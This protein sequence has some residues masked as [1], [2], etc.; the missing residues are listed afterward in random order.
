MP[1]EFLV[2]LLL[3]LLNGFFSL[4]EMALVSSRKARLK[5]EADKG[6]SAYQLAFKT[7]ESP[8]RYLSTIQVAITLI[9]I[10]TGTV[11]G[12]TIS[13]RLAAWLATFPALEK[14]AASISIAVVVLAITFLSVIIGELVPKSIALH[15]PE[16]IAAFTI[17]PMHF[18]SVLFFPV[19]RLLS[20]ATDGLVRLMGFHRAAE[21]AITPEEVKIL[22]EQG[23]ESGVFET[24][25]REMVEG[26]LNL[27]DRRVTMF[28]T[29][30]TDVVALDTADSREAHVRAIIEHAEFGYLPVVEGDLDHAI[31]MLE[32]KRALTR[33]A[34]GRF[35]G[36]RECMQSAVMIPESFSGL[37]ALGILKNA[38]KS[39]GLIVDE[40]GGVSGLVTI[41]DLLEVVANL[42]EIE[43]QEEPQIFKRSDGSYLVDG[44]MPID[45]FAEALELN[46]EQF[47][48][49][50]YD[51]VA[52]FV[53][54][55]TGTI[56]KA[57]DTIEWPPLSIEVVDMDG[58]R[59]DKVL[60]K[61][62][63]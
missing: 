29:P 24:A 26:V 15:N 34:Q 31:G 25:E 50:D 36:I 2:L 19:V 17:R 62:T 49:E 35:A 63:E 41:G 45:E 32:V 8:S 46:V 28:M 61:K 27:D 30:R 38:K 51:T 39:A 22:V 14:Y 57:G 42:S 56:P 53:L 47:S 6:K 13:Q 33:L 16:Q 40:Y 7:R 4:S 44:S 1:T 37:Q 23:E 20:A 21:S 48:R 43:Q 60:V 59:I 11:S 9:G 52:G 12:T 18:L 58:K 10:L 55:R 5:S 3:I 54:H